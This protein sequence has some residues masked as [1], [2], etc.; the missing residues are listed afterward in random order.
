MG[1]CLLILFSILAIPMI[2]PVALSTLVFIITPISD[3]LTNL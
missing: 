3:I 2:M 1:I